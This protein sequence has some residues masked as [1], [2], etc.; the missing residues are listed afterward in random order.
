M[1]A[2]RAPSNRGGGVVQL[3]STERSDVVAFLTIAVGVL[4]GVLLGHARRRSGD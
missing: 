4:A 1:V 3:L 2:V